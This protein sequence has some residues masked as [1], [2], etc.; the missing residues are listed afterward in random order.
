MRVVDEVCTEIE[1]DAGNFWGRVIDA[2]MCSDMCPCTDTDFATGGYDELVQSDL[3]KFDR[4]FQPSSSGSGDKATNQLMTQ[5]DLENW[6]ARG[7][8]W[9]DLTTLI[10]ESGGGIV[11][12]ASEPYKNGGNSVAETAD[13]SAPEPGTKRVPPTV[14]KYRDCYNAMVSS[15]IFESDFESD[16]TYSATN[17]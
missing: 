4:T 3:D 9:S 2:P 11:E 8:E 10:L 17:E 12:P 6:V 5:T 7:S 15:P 13:S 1:D 14:S 16:S